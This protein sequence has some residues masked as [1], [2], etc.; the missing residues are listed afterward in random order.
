MNA[1][2]RPSDDYRRVA[3]I[4]LGIIAVTFGL[5]GL[6]AAFVPLDS[7]VSGHG[8]VQASSNRQTIQHLEGGIVRAID[9]R[10]GDHVKAG[11]VLFELNPTQA[12]AALETARNELYSILAKADRLAAERD[13]RASI[14]FSPEVIAARG[15]PVVAQAITDQTREFDERRSALQGQIAVLNSRIAESRTVI[16]GIDQQRDSMV[17]QGAL[18]DDEISG[19]KELYAKDLVPK[20]RLIDLER[21][22]TQLRG[23]LGSAVAERAKTEQSIGET[24]LQIRSLQQ[25]FYQEVSK[26]M[27]E[28]QIQ[29][30]DLRQRF[31]VA[32]DAAKRVDLVA[33]M[34]G[35][36]QNL[37]FFTVGGVVRPGEPMVD[38]APDKTSMQ[39]EARFS[40]N[41]IDSVHVGQVA[42]LRFSSFHSRNTPVIKG[43]IHS[44]SQDRLA[45]EATHQPYYLAIVEIT[46]AQLPPE[47]Q[48]KLRAGL[49]VE[50]T[51]PTGSR[52]AL[53]YAFGPLTS[54]LNQSMRER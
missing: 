47:L 17:Q 25:Q 18:L 26:D 7:A 2:A 24:Q 45:D 21:E 13:N 5:I 31:A 3:L 38:I 34:S 37:R 16:Q 48:G 49:P 40:P 28:A 46:D 43:V 33:P 52:T 35:V 54:A 20:P 10:E 36:A 12:D 30:G 11:Q 14:S 6:W 4:G 42:T 29:I 22:R 9:V 1:I 44:I 19:L 51:V 23:Q 50:V 27:S 8:V 53:Q 32:Q 15:N 39:I 41:D